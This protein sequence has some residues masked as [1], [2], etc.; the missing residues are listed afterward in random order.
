MCRSG[1]TADICSS[2]FRY[3][4]SRKDAVEAERSPLVHWRGVV[5]DQ[6]I[7][8]PMTRLTEDDSP[9]EQAHLNF[10]SRQS[11][12]GAEDAARK[13]GTK[14]RHMI[15]KQLVLAGCT[16]VLLSVATAHAGP[17]NTDGKSAQDAGA[18]PTPGHTG[19]TIGSTGSTT[20]EHPPTNTMN[21]ATGDV[22]SSSQ[23]AQK[24]MQGQPTAAQ[25]GQGAQPSAKMKDQ[26]C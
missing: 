15:T 2:S 23:D 24:Q 1:S 16:A 13:D 19:Q 10:V 11:S 26:D 22:A 5:R 25:Q 20:A 3:Q 12:S 8:A 9:A 4:L 18:G 17:C 14:E 21:R 6:R 7:F